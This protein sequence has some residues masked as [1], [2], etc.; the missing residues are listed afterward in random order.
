MGR[1]G[2]LQIAQPDFAQLGIGKS[3]GQDSGQVSRATRIA[4]G[5]CCGCAGMWPRYQDGGQ[6]ALLAGGHQRRSRRAGHI[7]RGKIAG[8][9]TADELPRDARERAHD[10]LG[11]GRA[12][13]RILGQHA[14]D[15]CD[16][17]SRGFGPLAG[18]VHRIVEAD[19]GHDGGGRVAGKGRL[20]GKTFEEHAAQGEDVGA[21]VDGAGPAR[22][23][24]RHV[25]RRAQG[26]AGAGDA[27]VLAG[28]EKA[29]RDA[30]V[31]HLGLA[32]IAAR[33]KDIGWLDVA[34]DDPVS[35]RHGQSLGHAA[36]ELQGLGDAQRP[37]RHAVLQGLALQPLHH[38]VLLAAGGG[39]VGQI[40]HDCGVG[41]LGQ[42]QRLL[43]EA[44]GLRALRLAH[45]LERDEL[46]GLQILGAI[47]Q[48]HA[49]FDR[50]ALDA[51]TIAVGLGMVLGAHPLDSTGIWRAQ[52]K[53]AC[54]VS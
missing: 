6:H 4:C 25:Q 18:H 21:S 11:L 36:T 13:V 52:R 29:A 16:Q 3:L 48:A 33:Q 9:V 43:L 34:V 53:T 54:I 38:Q 10:L 22:L 42:H 24:G 2:V 39:A 5:G 23:F 41:N 44:Q 28:I 12:L 32:G 50:F 1:D 49:T 14:R 46:A 31:Q 45:Q 30:E 37:A 19:L 17:I 35:V 27:Q 15:Q 20:A 40:A 47:D 7:D 8:G 51:K 26:G